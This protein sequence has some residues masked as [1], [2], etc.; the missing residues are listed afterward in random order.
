MRIKVDEDLP[1]VV[2]QKLR[3][4]GYSVA[5]VLEQGL[6]GW[7]DRELWQVVQAEGR[8]LVT[9]DKGFADIRV[10]PPGTHAVVLLLRPDE[11]GI[12][13]LLELSDTVLRYYDLNALT[14]T[15]AVANP[16]GIRVR[17]V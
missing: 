11:D 5:S 12:R 10:Y 13:P 6:G 4:Q 1:P 7:K 17:R 14:G 2:A 9:A 16:R 3:K 8:F 15:V